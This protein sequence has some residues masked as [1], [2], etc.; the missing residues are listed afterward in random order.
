MTKVD[1]SDTVFRGLHLIFGEIAAIESR[2]P[3]NLGMQR[4]LP[5]PPSIFL[6]N[7]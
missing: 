6:A 3:W 5:G 7:R 2:P 1:R 4:P